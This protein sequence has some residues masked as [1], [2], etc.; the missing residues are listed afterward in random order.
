[1]TV[2]KDQLE[3]DYIFNN[4]ISGDKSAS[5]RLKFYQEMNALFD[6]LSPASQ[7]KLR[8]RMDWSK[9]NK[10][11]TLGEFALLIYDS[12][13]RERFLIESWLELLKENG[14]YKVLGITDAGGDNTGKV[15]LSPPAS[16][17]A[18]YIINCVGDGYLTSGIHNIEIKFAPSDAKLTYKVADLK[19][20]L[21]R[22]ES[23]LTIIGNNMIG[24][25]GKT[26]LNTLERKEINLQTFQWTYFTPQI[27]Q[28]LL[29]LP[30]TERYEMGGKPCIQILNKNFLNY[31]EL[32]SF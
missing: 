28:E 30:V 27:I 9:K 29:L 25:N 4:F 14:N 32:R 23:V 22:G 13:I 3:I 11:R 2:D 12:T 21:E 26:H 20:Y 7:G 19:N 17:G 1:M 10:G 31:F 8:R 18:D 24:P 16:R 15:Y 6:R 5:E